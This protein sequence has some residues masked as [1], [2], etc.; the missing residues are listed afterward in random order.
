MAVLSADKKFRNVINHTFT[1]LRL[2]YGL[3]QQQDDK[4]TTGSPTPLPNHRT[5]SN[6]NT[7]RHQDPSNVP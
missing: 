2:A 1:G 7:T 3:H 4:Q 5:A 6:K